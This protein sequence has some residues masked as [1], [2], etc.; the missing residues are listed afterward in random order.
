MGARREPC[1]ACTRGTGRLTTFVFE[2][3]REERKRRKRGKGGDAPCGCTSGKSALERA[4]VEMAVSSGKMIV[5]SRDERRGIKE[6]PSASGR[7]EKERE[8]GPSENQGLARGHHH[9]ASASPPSTFHAALSGCALPPNTQR[10]LCV[11]QSECT[12]REEGPL[13]ERGKTKDERRKMGSRARA[14]RG[15]P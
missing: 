5:E 14:M 11:R 9:A 7:A 12:E 10:R 13:R 4:A 6:E 8:E 3:R 1:R 15:S 2:D